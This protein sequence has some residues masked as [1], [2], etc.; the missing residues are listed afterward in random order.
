MRLLVTRPEPDAGAQAEELRNLGHEPVL[1]PLLEFHV[2]D[3]DWAAVETADALIFTSRNAL[4]A[5]SEKFDPGC[6]PACPVYCV[7]SETE[8]RLRQAGF[9]T[10]AAVAETAEELAGKIARTAAK[11]ASLVHV[12]GEH[13]AFDLAQALAR[14]GLCV[15]TLCVYAMRERSA[16]DSQAVEAFGA[17]AIGGV[18]L[19]SPRTAEIF[20]SLCR[21]HGFLDRARSLD[22]YCLAKSVA[23]RLK[24]LEPLHVHVAARPD[25]AALLELLPPLPTPGQDRV[26]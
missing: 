1:Q 21:R 5:L 19:M 3:F 8:R 25:R 18:L 20:V 12:T 26:R 7:G 2:L 16:F 9:Q 14:D 11:G 23:N 24:P 4:R 13:Q 15:S 6:I 10:I 17:G 22:Y